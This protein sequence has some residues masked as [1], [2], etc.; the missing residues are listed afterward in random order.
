M[1]ATTTA[2][3]ATFSAIGTTNTILRLCPARALYLP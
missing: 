3:A 1:D 2:M